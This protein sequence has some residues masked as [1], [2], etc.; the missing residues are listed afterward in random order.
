MSF[1]IS[2]PAVALGFWSALF[3]T[4]FRTA[5]VIAQLAEWMGLLGSNGGPDRASSTYGLA[6]LLTPSLFLGTSFLLLLL[7]IH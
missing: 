2:R 1:Q 4:I 6:I 5:Y 3:A 7:S